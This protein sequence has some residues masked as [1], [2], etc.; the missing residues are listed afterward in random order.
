[1]HYFIFRSNRDP[2][3]NFLAA[4]PLTGLRRRRRG[5]GERAHGGRLARTGRRLALGED[6]YERRRGGDD[7]DGIRR[8]APGAVV[9]EHEAA[10]EVAGGSA[11]SA[12]HSAGAHAALDGDAVLRQE[13]VE[14]D[15]LEI[16]IF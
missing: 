14:V 15:V 10:G 1:M 12:G 8:Q 4:L 2:R 7:A 5:N 9:L 16:E 3:D 11:D 13:L 6:G